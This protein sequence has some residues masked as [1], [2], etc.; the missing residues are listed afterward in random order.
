MYRLHQSVNA[1]QIFATTSK[2]SERPNNSTKRRYVYHT[3][4]ERSSCGKQNQWLF[5]VDQGNGIET[6]GRV[7]CTGGRFLRNQVKIDSLH[8]VHVGVT[9]RAKKQQNNGHPK[10]SI[11]AVVVGR[12]TISVEFDFYL[13]T[14]CVCAKATS[15][16]LTVRSFF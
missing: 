2:R 11:P 6:V 10:H 9:C 4:A 8:I 13:F 14:I 15:G 1:N 16:C 5:V 3:V 7:K 12:P